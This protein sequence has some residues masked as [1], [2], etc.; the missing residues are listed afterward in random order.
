MVPL[1]GLEPEHPKIT[2]FESVASTNSATEACDCVTG[3]IQPMSND[4]ADSK[5]RACAQ[6]A[7]RG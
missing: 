1:S 6:W 7:N 5:P 3:S 4:R 2:D